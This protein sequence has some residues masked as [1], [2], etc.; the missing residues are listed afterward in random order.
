[1]K[2]LNEQI[3]DMSNPGKATVS[4]CKRIW[5]LMA[6]ADM[7]PQW[8][9]GIGYHEAIKMQNLLERLVDALRKQKGDS[10]R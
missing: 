1:M 8:V 6:A 2:R 7:K 10:M 9:E 5:V 3:Q 4:Q